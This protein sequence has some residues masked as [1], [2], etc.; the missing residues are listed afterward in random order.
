MD[1]GTTVGGTDVTVGTGVAVGGTDVAVGTG[2]GVG[3]GMG[4][5]VA[6][7]GS[8]S[9]VELT[10]AVTAFSNASLASTVCS[11]KLCTVASMSGVA[12]GGR[13]GTAVADAVGSG[14]LVA[15]SAVAQLARIVSTTS[16]STGKEIRATIVM[17]VLGWS[18]E[19][20]HLS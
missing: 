4:V 15:V 10:A 12:D 20:I 11:T 3:L 13:G 14:T 2:V 6:E 7:I 5:G 9:R 19:A 17:R 8:A 18:L 16:S 1:V